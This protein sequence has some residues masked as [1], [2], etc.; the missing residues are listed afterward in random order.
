MLCNIDS[1]DV[2]DQNSP[3]RFD[4]NSLKELSGHKIRLLE[5][6]LETWPPAAVILLILTI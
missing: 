2:L 1:R 4:R 3:F 5:A 6:F